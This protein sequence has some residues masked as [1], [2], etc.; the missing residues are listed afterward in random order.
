MNVGL[1]SCWKAMWHSAIDTT[2]A[3]KASMSSQLGI[4]PPLG[5]WDTDVIEDMAT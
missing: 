1:Q 5:V 3:S 2:D 4:S